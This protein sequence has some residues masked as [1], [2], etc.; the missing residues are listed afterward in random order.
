MML[1]RLNK[2]MLYRLFAVFLLAS[3]VACNRAEVL[4]KFTSPAEQTLAKRYIDLLRQKQFDKIEAAADE[5]I[6]GDNLH[7]TLLAMADAMPAGEPTS[8]MLVGAHRLIQSGATT[9]NL[10]FEYSFGQRWI[11]TNV[12]IKTQDEKATIVGMSVIPQ[13]AS[14]IEQNRFALAGKSAMQYTVLLLV[15]VALVFTLFVLVVCV[16]TKLRGRKWPWLLFI[17]FGF[18][19]LSVNWTTAAWGFTPLALQMF[20]AAAVAE[21]YGPWILKVSFPLGAVLFL[22]RRKN[23]M[24]G[25]VPAGT[26]IGKELGPLQQQPGVTG[27]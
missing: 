13:P 15:P 24:V 3:L 8:I 14:I 4:Q 21:P 23:L 19:N 6:A 27:Q 22:L 25:P 16:R 20:S 2:P 1:A 5:K 12:A 7:A 10:T 9:V 11:L 17:L 18:G 26:G